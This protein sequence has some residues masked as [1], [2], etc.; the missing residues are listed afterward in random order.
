MADISRRTLLNR[1]VLASA[2]GGG[3]LLGLTR[4]VRHQIAKPPPPA[5]AA[6]TAALDR[7]RRLLAG[8]DQAL[9]SPPS[10][11]GLAGLRADVA[12]HGEALQAVLQRYPGW[13]LAVASSAQGSAAASGIATG[14]GSTATP[15]GTALQGTVAALAAASRSAAAAT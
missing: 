8:Y 10:N 3:A 14:P 15:G 5:P 4:P 12:A 11:P 2:L 1:A 13:R 9:A 6:L 7:Q